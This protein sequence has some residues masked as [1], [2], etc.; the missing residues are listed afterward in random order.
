MAPFRGWI[1]K[2]KLPVFKTSAVSW[3]ISFQMLTSSA[4]WK[5]ALPFRMRWAYCRGSLDSAPS[6]IPQLA[7]SSRLPHLPGPCR[8]SCRPPSHRHPARQAC[9][10]RS[11]RLPVCF[12]CVYVRAARIC[13]CAC[14]TRGTSDGGREGRREVCPSLRAS[15]GVAEVV[16]HRRGRERVGR[17][18]LEGGRG[19]GGDGVVDAQS[20]STTAVSPSRSLSLPLSR[21]GS[22]YGSLR[23]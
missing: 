16:L 1:H 19:G 12:V 5:G 21:F 22:E 17:G 4:C 20:W 3:S 14:G 23:S 13:T 11:K 10:R 7:P 9:W 18:R 8:P 15:G 6:S 2:K